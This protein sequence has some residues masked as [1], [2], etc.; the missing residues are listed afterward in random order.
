M[1]RGRERK[2]VKEKKKKRKKEKKK[3]DDFAGMVRSAACLYNIHIGLLFYNACPRVI[4][5]RGFAWETAG[6]DRG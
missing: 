1:L 2:E 4:S 6:L 3:K 5:G